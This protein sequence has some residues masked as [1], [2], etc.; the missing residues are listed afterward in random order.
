[1][2]GK[3]KCELMRNIRKN[4]AEKNNLFYTPCECNHEGDCPGYCPMCDKEAE[5]LMN[6]LKEEMV[7]ELP[8][9]S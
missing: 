9:T 4:I 1:M 3:E 7:L 6:K 2:N 5:R 8:I